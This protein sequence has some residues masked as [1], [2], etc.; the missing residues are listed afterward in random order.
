MKILKRRMQFSENDYSRLKR[1]LVTIACLMIIP[2]I[3]LMGRAVLF[4]VVN[5]VITS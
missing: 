4:F 2:L 5:P 3:Y 1:T